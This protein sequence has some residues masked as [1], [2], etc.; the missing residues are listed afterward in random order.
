MRCARGL[1][2]SALSRVPEATS[3][4][5][6]YQ[7]IQADRKE[8]ATREAKKKEFEQYPLRYQ[9]LECRPGLPLA[10]TKL[11]YLL[12]CRRTH[13][14][15][16]GDAES[17][18]R[19]NLAYQDVMKDYG[20]ETVDNKIVN[21]GNFQTDDQEAQNYLEARAKITSY[22][23]ISTLEDHIKQIEEIQGRLG[24][25]LSDKLSVNSDEAM[26]L[27]EDIEDVM[28]QTGLKTVKVKVLEDGKVHLNDVQAL[29]DGTEKPLFLTDDKERAKSP[30][31]SSATSDAEAAEKDASA[32]SA[33]VH[34]DASTDA[35][36]DG[37]P[38]DENALYEAVVSK[39][40]IEVL[41]AKNTLQDRP[42]V[43]GLAA[44]TATEVMN[45]TEEV[46]RMKLE[47][48]VL[49]VFLV[50]LMALVYIYIE[51]AM[52]AKRQASSRPE[53]MEHVT[54][55][56]MLPWWGNDAEYESQV[57][58]IFVDEW[59]KAR[60]SSR[61]SQTFQD[62]VARESLDED[63]KKEM[64]LQIFTVTAEKLRA[65]RDNAEKH[66]GR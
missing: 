59:R 33:E 63:T 57:K 40:D 4:V 50:S 9:I 60:A 38:S 15:A 44:R 36:K 30:T 6:D 16:G 7:R 47:S 39:N 27:L 52:R 37:A 8:V 3:V 26:W 45:N 1:L 54:S 66:P 41:N 58:R 48:S 21:L 53:T 10:L 19:V 29:T 46:K 2:C 61:R 5:K 35:A 18:L 56:T 24:D 34:R 62:G 13:P 64:D 42:D 17:F 65:M 23:P 55:D 11:K 22:I 31:G 20:V 14:E 25:E 28:E 12:A 49:Y 43:A 32:E 51:G